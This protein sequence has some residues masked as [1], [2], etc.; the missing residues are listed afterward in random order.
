MFEFTFPPHDIEMAKSYNDGEIAFDIYW[1]SSGWSDSVFWLSNSAG[2]DWFCFHTER[3]ERDPETNEKIRDWEEN[4]WVLKDEL[5]LFIAC[6]S[7]CM[8]A[9]VA[10]RT[11]R[12]D[13]AM[14][15]EQGEYCQIIRE[16]QTG[17]EIYMVSRE[18]MLTLWTFLS[19]DFDPDE[20]E[21][22]QGK[23]RDNA[24]RS[25]YGYKSQE[26]PLVIEKDGALKDHIF[27]PECNLLAD[28]QWLDYV[29]GNGR[30]YECEEKR[31][32]HSS[33]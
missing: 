9:C 23:G 33:E 8:R 31:K 13:F 29:V 32:S 12:F 1:K 3:T 22:V 11:N 6:A 15:R 14:D 5:M 28:D 7:I 21:M 30:C 4:I 10:V 25:R 27:C 26:K 16:I 19:S 2:D 24:F 17:H 18:D 20:T